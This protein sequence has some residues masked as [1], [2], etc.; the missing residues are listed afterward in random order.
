MLII[1][2]N[3]QVEAFFLDSNQSLFN[4]IAFRLQTLPR[5]LYIHDYNVKEE[6]HV[7][8]LGS[9]TR[10][11]DKLPDLIQ[12][13]SLSLEQFIDLYSKESDA[14][15]MRPSGTS[16][17]RPSDAPLGRP[18]GKAVF[19][20]RDIIW[21]YKS[22]KPYEL[23]ATIIGNPDFETKY[24]QVIY[25][26]EKNHDYTSEIDK[27]FG[28]FMRDQYQLLERF[29]FIDQIPRAPILF[30]P[31]VNASIRYQFRCAYENLYSIFNRLT[32]TMDVPFITYN[33]YYKVLRDYIPPQ[34]W[35]SSSDKIILKIRSLKDNSNEV[36]YET[37]TIT[38]FEQNEFKIELKQDSGKLE[39]ILQNIDCEITEDR[40]IQIG[41]TM[42]VDQ[43]LD[44]NIWADIMMTEPILLEYIAVNDRIRH[45]LPLQNREIF[46]KFDS[47]ESTQQSVQLSMTHQISRSAEIYPLNTAY[48]QFRILSAPDERSIYMTQELLSRCITIYRDR[49][50]SI[51]EIY[52][53]YVGEE[54]VSTNII[55]DERKEGGKKQQKILFLKDRIPEI[56]SSKGDEIYSRKCQSTKQPKIMETEEEA[57][58]EPN[59]VMLFPKPSDSHF[60]QPKYYTCTEEPY[61]HIGLI[62]FNNELG[63]APCCFKTDQSNKK[64]YKQYFEGVEQI[65]IAKKTGAYF[66]RTNKVIL[67]GNYGF[68]PSSDRIINHI[69]TFFESI[70]VKKQ[71]VMRYG[72]E[73]SPHSFLQ[74]VLTALGD[75]TNVKLERS[76]LAL[77]PNLEI[78][79][80]EMFAISINEMREILMSDEY[81]DPLQFVRL[82]EYVYQV[83]IVLFT[84]G[85]KDGGNIQIPHHTHG[86]CTY[87]RDT[88]L[89]SIFIYCHTGG[90][91]DLLPYP[92]CELIFETT[93][94]DFQQLK[95]N[96]EHPIPKIWEHNLFNPIYRGVWKAFTKLTRTYFG[97]YFTVPIR[98]NELLNTFSVRSQIIDSY[99]KT[100]ALEV[101]FEGESFYFET[102]PIAPLP[103][104]IAQ[105]SIP[106][107]DS[108]D[109]ITRFIEFHELDSMTKHL[110]MRREGEPDS[111]HFITAN[112]KNSVQFTFYVGEYSVDMF[113][114]PINIEVG[115]RHQPSIYR[116]F[117]VYSKL[118]RSM[119]NWMLRLFSE[120]LQ[121]N[122]VESELTS[123]TL[124]NFISKHCDID[125]NVKYNPS[126]ISEVFNDDRSGVIRGRKIV[127]NSVE[128]LKRLIYQLRL[129]FTRNRDRVLSFYQ[130]TTMDSY[131]TS[132]MDFHQFPDEIMFY[133]DPT[134]PLPM[135]S[136][137]RPRKY[138]LHSTPQT[139]NDPYFFKHSKITNNRIALCQNSTMENAIAKLNIWEKDKVN[140]L[141][142]MIYREKPF[143]M[144]AVS[145][146]GDS[147]AF[148]I[149]EDESPR[150]DR[151]AMYFEGGA[152]PI[153]FL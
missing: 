99:G 18:S 87:S 54:K 129:L 89:P 76:R 14:S 132:L 23:N 60:S 79:K 30:Q 119:T 102:T 47:V 6:E 106:P 70:N 59:T 25:E 140:R 10:V 27:E 83:N 133:L 50:N 139:T 100:R 11:A 39:E 38:H 151:R 113:G 58:N 41:S 131:Y 152:T 111:V 28:E 49:Y 34:E 150:I 20:V 66:I 124:T 53:Q 31:N 143:Y 128:L 93:E 78:C 105:E 2:F 36:Q 94:Y 40:K 21:L 110:K 104:P 117:H 67:D 48:T 121:E 92:Q 44:H 95:K 127:C 115:Y 91:M 43:T 5:Y 153:M 29:I 144:F 148:S 142:N 4:R 122:P 64:I 77:H 125:E 15:S 13:S 126:L 138:V 22:I 116:Q 123:R 8:L 81:L 52:K 134:N 135:T 26:I 146:K 42:T 45:V 96:L 108:I 82:I 107:L 56:F 118:A 19:D 75:E 72:V 149:T 51:Y 97:P 9:H 12:Q 57:K 33:H 61:T 112:Y 130:K 120:Y 1:P 35:L 98:M 137:V 7:E 114:F 147:T 63:V 103:V 69:G 101:D 46:L 65:P 141:E 85:Q 84:K 80:Q 109:R 145:S 73:Q 3:I 74:C 62:P 136:L 17:M 90:E 37:A 55:V 16:S 32:T 24:K 71:L 68:F 88:T 86:Y